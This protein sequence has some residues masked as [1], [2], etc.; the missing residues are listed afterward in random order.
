[1]FDLF[2]GMKDQMDSVIRNDAAIDARLQQIERWVLGERSIDK[3]M[4]GAV[5]SIEDFRKYKKWTI[6]TLLSAIVAVVMGVVNFF[7]S[8]V[9]N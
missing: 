8:K 7:V 3:S 1:M 5:Q 2:S 9:M 6:A 4:E